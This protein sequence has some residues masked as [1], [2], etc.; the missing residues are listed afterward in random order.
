MKKVLSILWVGAVFLAY[1][2]IVWLPKLMQKVG[3]G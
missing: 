1:L 3:G 2:G